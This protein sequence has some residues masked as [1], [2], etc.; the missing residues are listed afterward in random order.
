[1]RKGSLGGSG[2]PQGVGHEVKNPWW[3]RLKDQEDRLTER[4]KM[5]TLGQNPEKMGKI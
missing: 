3:G 1:M 4:M 2:K 5:G